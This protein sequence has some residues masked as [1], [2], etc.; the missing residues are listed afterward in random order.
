MALAGHVGVDLTVTYDS[1]LIAGQRNASLSSK[2]DMIEMSVKA[3]SP[4][5]TF[6]PGWQEWTVDCDGLLMAN[7]TLGIGTL[8]GYQTAR[9]P[10]TL[11]MTI[12]TET[13][14]GSALIESLSADGPQDKEGTCKVTFRG[15][16]TLTA[17]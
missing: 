10:L 5:K 1:A 9:T 6:L 4:W 15:T 8:F 16:S 2:T 13:F 3:D 17:G 7:D 12:G 14:T 11:V